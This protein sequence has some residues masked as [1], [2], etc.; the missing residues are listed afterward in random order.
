M[1]TEKLTGVT[2]K[3]LKPS[4]NGQR[5]NYF[6]MAYRGLCL[7]VGKRDKTWTYHYRFNGQSRSP[8]LGKY[9]PGRVD[10]MD[11]EAAIRAASEIDR[12]VDQGIDPKSTIKRTRRNPRAANA[13][14]FESRVKEFLQD[15]KS[16]RGRPRVVKEKTFRHAES[17]LQ[18][19][20]VA[21]LKSTDV[22]SITRSNIINAL[23]QMSDTP[24]QANRLHSYLSVFFG[25]CLDHEYLELSPIAHLRK[26]FPEA[27]RTRFLSKNEI[28]GFWIGCT[29]LGYPLGDYAKF[30]L[31]TG[32]RPG[33]CRNLNTGDIDG[34]IWL[35]EGGDPKNRERH[36]LPLTGVALDIVKR[37][38]N[39][40]GKYIFS[41]SNGDAPFAQGDKQMN[42]IRKAADLDEHWTL[43]D[44]RRTFTTQASEELD[45][46]P[47]IIGVIC[48]Q[49]TVAKPG[50]SRVYNQAKWLKQ[51]K[52]ALDNWSEWLLNNVRS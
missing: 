35:V 10:H 14:A 44:L 40:A 48:N 19:D 15:Y 25:W 4:K 11:R 26:R 45:F 16:G 46:E 38:P 24:T 9:C 39:A 22:A 41:Y 13:N 42:Q 36:R 37:S 1:P 2:I 52:E 18:S 31:A 23:D 12:L 7:R 33:E 20:Y 43:R 32:Q 49:K 30:V 51:K 47:H 34:E 8:S 3:N 5:V 17:L 27:P 6:D 21:A 50:V 29:E 28:K